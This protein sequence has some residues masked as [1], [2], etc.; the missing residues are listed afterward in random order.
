MTEHRMTHLPETEGQTAVDDQKPRARCLD[1]D[2]NNVQQ[3]EVIL[4]LCE[5]N[6]F[7]YGDVWI[8]LRKTCPPGTSE[9]FS[10]MITLNM[11]SFKKNMEAWDMHGIIAVDGS[12][13]DAN[14]EGRDKVVGFLLYQIHRETKQELELLFLLVDMTY[15]SKGHASNMVK[16]CVALHLSNS[17][18]DVAKVRNDSVDFITVKVRGDN[19]VSEFYK[20]LGFEEDVSKSTEVT[21]EHNNK[22][23]TMVRARKK[24]FLAALCAGMQS[25][26]TPQEQ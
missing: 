12:K 8:H 24:T 25:D 9:K 18:N 17:D 16:A 5:S 13:N 15:R 6:K 22:Y 14:L 4:R 21:E 19:T 26:T 23:I 11:V 3:Q 7:Q 20:K 2:V 10:A 1:M